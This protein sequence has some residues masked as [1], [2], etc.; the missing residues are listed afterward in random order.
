MKI[1]IDNNV[2]IS[3][4][5]W[6]GAPNEI[7]KLAEEEKLEISATLEIID[8]LFGVLKRNKFEKLFEEAAIEPEY[9]FKKIFELVK[10]YSCKTIMRI[11]KEDPSDDKFLTCALAVKADFIISG[12]KHLLKLKSF[13]NIPI[14]TPREFMNRFKK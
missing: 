13:Q 12:D 5:F 8:E 2:F 10:I 3:G 4:I 6:K 1:I 14:L 11:I 9:I 7:I